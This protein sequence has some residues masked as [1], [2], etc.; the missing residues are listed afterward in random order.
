MTEAEVSSP[1]IRIPALDAGSSPNHRD[2]SY[3]SGS[4][5]TFATHTRTSAST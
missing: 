2:D 4:P 5:F 1:D 3:S